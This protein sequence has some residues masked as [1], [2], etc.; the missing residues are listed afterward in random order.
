MS[1]AEPWIADA[2]ARR[3]AVPAPSPERVRRLRAVERP[4][5]RRRPRMA[6][7]LVALIGALL[8]AGTQIVLS[9]LTTQ[10]SYRVADLLQERR[11]LT[12]QAQQ[13]EDA[14]AGLSSP[15]YLAANA[16]SMGMVIDSSP[17]YLRLSDGM[18]LGE[19]VASGSTS[20]VDARS[21]LVGN[22]LLSETPLT[23]DPTRTLTGPVPQRDSAVETEAAGAAEESAEPEPTG[24][25]SLDDGLPSPQTH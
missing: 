16:A 2:S 9:M 7:G 19:E 12:L 6:Y 17:S 3:V 23:A 24:P 10:D 25:P 21:S 22:A 14:V 18:L 15:Q 5:P 1:L 11:D 8:I 4:A 13:L 20:T